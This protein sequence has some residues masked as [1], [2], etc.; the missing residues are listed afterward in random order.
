MILLFNRS[1]HSG[2]DSS[3]GETNSE[4]VSYQPGIDYS[5]QRRDMYSHMSQHLHSKWCVFVFLIIGSV[6][7]LLHLLYKLF[8]VLDRQYPAETC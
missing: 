6:Q 4:Q 8:H 2:G 5:L 3:G 7:H 1:L